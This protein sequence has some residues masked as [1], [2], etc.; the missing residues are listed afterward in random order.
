MVTVSRQY[1]SL[2]LQEECLGE[3]VDRARSTIWKNP[4]AGLAKQST[5]DHLW[6]GNEGSLAPPL[7]VLDGCTHFGLHTAPGKLPFFQVTVRFAQRQLVQVARTRLAIVERD[8]FHSG[9]DE[10]EVGMQGTRQQARGEIFIDDCLDAHQFTVFSGDYRNAASTSADDD[11][12]GADHHL[13]ERA[14]DD[15]PWIGRWNNP[16]PAATGIFHHRPTLFA[17]FLLGLISIVE[18][19]YRL[20]GMVQHVPREFR[21]QQDKPHLWSITVSNDDVPAPG[22]HLSDVY[23]CFTHGSLLVGQGLVSA[24]LNE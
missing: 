24:I 13:N 18:Q 16:P 11:V 6:H 17:P 14:L 1:S 20:A 22:N 23:H 2:S 21:T 8:F 15:A 19:S 4:G 7:Q 9:R 3:C 10:Q 12:A 5:G